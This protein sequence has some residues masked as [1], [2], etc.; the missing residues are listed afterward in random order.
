MVWTARLRARSP[1]RLSRW[2][3][4]LELA[5]VDFQSLGALTECH[6]EP[7]NLVMAN[8]MLDGGVCGKPAAGQGGERGVGQ[9]RAAEVTVSVGAAEEQG[10]QPVGLRG[11]RGGQFLAGSEQDAQGFTDAVGARGGQPVGVE[12]QRGEH[13]EVRVDRIG[14]AAAPPGLPRRLVALEDRQAGRGQ[15][16]S[17]ADAEA[18]GALDGDHHSR[19]GT[20]LSDPAEQLEVARAGVR[21]LSDGQGRAGR[22]GELGDVDIAVGVDSDHRVNDFGQHRH[23]LLLPGDCGE[24]GQ[25]P[26]WGT[27]RHICEGSRAEADK[28]LIKPAGGPGRCR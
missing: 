1:P 17:Q 6:A 5:P 26:G 8:G 7:A 25:R 20:V 19:S 3:T 16:A 12:L 9:R 15:R 11:G 28:L 13:G 21:D 14:L 23:G 4:L 2:R 18:A 22:A 27:E 24:H 10:A